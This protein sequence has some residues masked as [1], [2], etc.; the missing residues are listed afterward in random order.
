M[1]NEMVT[2][3]QELMLAK[4]E[5]EI[6][7]LKFE[8]QHL[9][10]QKAS[11][12]EDSLF[13]PALFDH[14]EKVAIFMAESGMVPTSYKGKPKDIMVAFAMGYQLG[15]AVEQSLQDIAII[16]GRP[17]LWGDGLMALALSHPLCESIIENEIIEKGITIG[18]LC[19]VKRKGF[20]PHQVSFTIQ[21]AQTAGLYKKAGA[22]TTYPR[23]MLQLRARS[24]AL[25]DRFSD[26]LRGIKIAE[27][28]Q[29]DLSIIEGEIV[30]PQSQVKKLKDILKSKEVDTDTGEIIENED[31][32]RLITED[33]MNH[34]L[35]IMD[36]KE[37]T[38]DRM[39]KALAYFKIDSFNNLTKKDYDLFL[40]QLGK[41]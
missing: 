29:E 26:A 20:E 30:K 36:E 4:Q 18:Y 28:E 11:R 21:D 7:K 10:T 39:D 13:S 2:M 34:V 32:S 16:N 23:R 17:C 35:I 27:I 40:I 38:K 6:M 41:A 14:Y 5:S 37:F 22:W 1:S 31:A 25:R 8:L 24:L 15:F 9:Q 3:Q 19:T 12:L 33:E